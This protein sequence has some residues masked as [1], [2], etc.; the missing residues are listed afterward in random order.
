MPEVGK[1]C[2]R[3][4]SQRG[5]GQGNMETDRQNPFPSGVTTVVLYHWGG[6]YLIPSISAFNNRDKHLEVFFF[7]VNNAVKSHNRKTT[8][9]LNS[10]YKFL[11]VLATK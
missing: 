11:W 3:S 5:E 9:R 2:F 6:C 4:L 1:K 7:T 10:N 8:A